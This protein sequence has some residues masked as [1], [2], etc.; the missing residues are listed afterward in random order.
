MKHLKKKLEI[1]TLTSNG[2][3]TTIDL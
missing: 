3:K 2:W 1:G